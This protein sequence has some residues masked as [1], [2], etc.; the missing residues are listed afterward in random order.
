MKHSLSLCLC[1][2]LCMMLGAAAL[3]ETITLNGVVTVKNT[4]EVYAPIG[5]TVESVAVTPGQQVAAGDVLLSLKTVKHYASQDGVVTGVFAQPGDSADTIA[6][7]Y[8]GVLYIEGANHFTLVA[9]TESAYSSAA[10]KYVYV[11]ET[12]YLASRT[13]RTHVS[14]G[15]VTAVNGIDFS[16]EAI[17]GVFEIGETCDVFRSADQA[18]K[19]RI[20]RGTIGR[21]NPEAVKGEGSIVSIA[22]ASGDTVTRGQLLFETLSGTYDGLYMSGRDVCTDVAGIVGS[23]NANSGGTLQ[24]GSV[25]AVI[26]PTG[27]MQ[28]EATVNETDLNA[29]HVG[30][31]VTIEMNWNADDGALLRGTVAMI[32]AVS[33]G[34]G[35][36]AS[37]TVYIDFTPDENTRYGMTAFISTVEAEPEA[38]ETPEAEDD[39]DADAAPEETPMPTRAPRGGNGAPGS[40]APN[41]YGRGQ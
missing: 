28:L 41:G 10:N 19:S 5:G 25:A 20:G 13:E 21:I 37:Y 2:V 7:R 39:A 15:V 9:T 4:R 14:E 8:G 33:T 34:S 31:P 16:V 1:L 3:A 24:K 23:V 40:G 29:I 6:A 27:A 38:T 32:S 11:G 30:D 18:A 17:G 35:S 22:V 36:T 26:Y 12:V